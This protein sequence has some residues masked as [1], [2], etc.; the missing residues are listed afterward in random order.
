MSF[1]RQV[2]P[3]FWTGETGRELK[4]LPPEER[5]AA[6]VVALYL[7]TAPE[8]QS[9][10]L[11]YLPVE[12][13]ALNTGLTSKGAPKALR[14]VRSLGFCEVDEK[15]GLIFVTEM[16]SYQIG[17]TLKEGDKRKKGVIN[18]LKP[19]RKSPL[20][21]SFFERYGEAYGLENPWPFEAPPK[22]EQ[23][24][25]ETEQEQIKDTGIESGKTKLAARK[26]I[27]KD[28]VKRFNE[29]F[30]R[31]LDSKGFEA[32]VGRALDKGFSHGELKGAFWWA[33]IEWGQDPEFR[34]KITPETILKFKSGH[35]ARTLPTYVSLAK[36]RF[37]ELYPNETPPWE[38][39]A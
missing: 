32:Q 34:M 15:R 14:R 12:L 31:N 3:A 37:A 8:S 4:Q 28:L 19:F 21:H 33:A 20:I 27:A 6:Q 39:V 18:A 5:H 9:T 1:Y 13:I 16:A 35:G 7:M 2:Y 30:S 25:T 26:K 24:R 17:A 22:P 11:F 10:G 38:N 29:G 36:E 23:N